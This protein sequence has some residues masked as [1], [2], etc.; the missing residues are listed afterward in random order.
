MPIWKILYLSSCAT[1][2]YKGDTQNGFSPNEI[3]ESRVINE[4]VVVK[5]IAEKGKIIYL[6]VG[7]GGHGLY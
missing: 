6:F 3:K 4:K 7:G 2:R 5:V 1:I